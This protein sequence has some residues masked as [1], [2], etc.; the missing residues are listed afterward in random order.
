MIYI[1]VHRAASN[2]L[3]FA[4][5]LLLLLLL[6]LLLPSDIQLTERLRWLPP[7]KPPRFDPEGLPTPKPRSVSCSPG[8]HEAALEVVFGSNFW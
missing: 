3:P 6:R 4:P 1:E 7:S 8:C 2:S 5:M